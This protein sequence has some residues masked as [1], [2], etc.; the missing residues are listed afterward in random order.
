MRPGWVFTIL[1][2]ITIPVLLFAIAFITSAG[3]AQGCSAVKELNEEAIDLGFKEY[4]PKTG[5]LVWVYELKEEFPKK[6]PKD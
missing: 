2:T 6:Y 5:K 3:I 4:H 1:M